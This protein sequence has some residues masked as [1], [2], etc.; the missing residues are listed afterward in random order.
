MDDHIPKSIYYI[1]KKRKK[2]TNLLVH[3]IKLRP[4][5]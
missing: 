5:I 3:S 4:D 2:V 1:H